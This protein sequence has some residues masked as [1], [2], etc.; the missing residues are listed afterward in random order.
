MPALEDV[1]IFDFSRDD[2]DV[3]AEAD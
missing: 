3:G 2:D 1:S